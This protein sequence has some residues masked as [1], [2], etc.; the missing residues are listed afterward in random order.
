[1]R[2]MVAAIHASGG[3]VA[4]VSAEEA[5]ARVPLLRPGYLAAAAFDSD[6]TDIDVHALHEGFLRGA[7]ASG[8]RI[9]TGV[10]ARQIRREQRMWALD[11]AGERLSAPV[12]INAA[13]A[14]ADEVAAACGA[15]P[16]GLTPLRRTALLVD[17]PLG[18]DISGWPAVIDADEEFYFKPEAGKLLLSPAD[19]TPDHAGDAP[20][21]ELEIAAGVDRVEAAPAIDVPRLAHCEAR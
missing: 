20:P 8:T 15:R 5:L 21:P 11:L 16:A 12:L 2:Q 10:W 14:W 19:E 7:R 13:G 17:P 3:H 1:L 9:V 4:Y 6:A 18:V